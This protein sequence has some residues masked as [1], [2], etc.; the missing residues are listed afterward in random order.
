MTPTSGRPGRWPA[1]SRRARSGHLVCCTSGDAGADDADID[2]LDAGRHAR[3]RAAGRGGDRR[4]RG[5]DL[6]AR[7]GRRP[8][9]RPAAARAA[10][11]APPHLPSRRR[12]DDGPLGALQPLRLDPAHRP[13]GGGDGRVDAVYPAARN[14]DGFPA[15]RQAWPR[16]AHRA[17]GCTCSGRTSPMPG[18][19]RARPSSRKLEA[20]RAH[21]SQIRQPDDTRGA[22]ARVGRRGR[23]RPWASTPRRASGSSTWPDRRRM[24]RAAAHAAP[25]GSTGRPAPSER[26]PRS[27]TSSPSERSGGVRGEIL[28]GGHGHARDTARGSPPRWASGGCDAGSRPA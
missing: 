22:H 5:R 7:A 25:T 4:L 15:P 18:S 17:P 23:E 26:R 10:G 19:T 9:Q 28:V 8:R 6:P 14:A 27:A 3:G 2:P 1:G 13:P 21:A 11:R 20:L 12:A 24:Q 16:T